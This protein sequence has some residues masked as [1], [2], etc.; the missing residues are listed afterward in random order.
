[1]QGFDVHLYIYIYRV[2][3]LSS[4]LYL[5]QCSTLPSTQKAFGVT[6]ASLDI[7]IY[8]YILPVDAKPLTVCFDIS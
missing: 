2:Y 6:Y 7:Y 3:T 1:M 5:M 8:I 4:P